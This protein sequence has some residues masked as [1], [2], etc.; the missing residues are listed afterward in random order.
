MFSLLGKGRSLWGAPFPAR[1]KSARRAAALRAAR[2][3][4]AAGSGRGFAAAGAPCGRA[5]AHRGIFPL[6]SAARTR[7]NRDRIP[8]EEPMP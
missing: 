4:S 7:Y 6:G 2:R 3:P 5:C 8:K 1:G